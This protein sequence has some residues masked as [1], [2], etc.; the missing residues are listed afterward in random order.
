[1]KTIFITLLL[2]SMYSYTNAQCTVVCNSSMNVSLDTDMQGIITSEILTQGNISDCNLEVGLF[3]TDNETQV[4]PYADTLFVNCDHLGDFLFRVR[5][6]DSGNICF[7]TLSTSDQLGSCLTNTHDLSD[8]Q[9]IDLGD[10]IKIEL[11]DYTNTSLVVYNIIGH[12][13]FNLAIN[14]PSMFLAKH[15][16]GQKG[17]YVLSITN[18]EALFSRKFVIL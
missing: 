10:R 17:H 11:S 13:V 16:I 4:I 5:D 7:G 6:K 12:Q 2:F 15:D 14:S 9:I 8:T 3:E 18:G 1:M